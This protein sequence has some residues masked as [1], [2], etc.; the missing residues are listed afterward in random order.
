MDAEVAAVVRAAC[1][2]NGRWVAASGRHW[3][4]RRCRDF[5]IN[6]L[7]WLLPPQA[8]HAEDLEKVEP[9]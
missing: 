2:K 9:E 6:V 4:D 5:R 8:R 3:P 7:S 1:E